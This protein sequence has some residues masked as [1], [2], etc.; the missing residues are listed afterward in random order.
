VR[1]SLGATKPKGAV[2]V[3]AG[4]VGRGGIRGVRAAAHHRPVAASA[5]ARRS[6]SVH[7]G[8]RKMVNYA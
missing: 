3:K 6:K 4:S 8:T 1:K 5:Y 7:V 2:K